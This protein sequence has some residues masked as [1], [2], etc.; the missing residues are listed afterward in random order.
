MCKPSASPARRPVWLIVSSITHTTC[1]R[2]LAHLRRV[3]G[4]PWRV[5]P[6]RT[7]PP[8]AHPAPRVRTP[9]RARRRLERSRFVDRG[10]GCGFA[11]FNGGCGRARSILSAHGHIRANVMTRA[12]GSNPRTGRRLP[13]FLRA[14]PHAGAGASVHGRGRLRGR[15]GH[16]ADRLSLLRA[17]HAPGSRLSQGS[18]E[19]TTLEGTTRHGGHTPAL[20]CPGRLGVAGAALRGNPRAGRATPTSTRRISGVPPPPRPP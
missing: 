15:T 20:R 10:S 8:L 6:V 7:S 5:R 13:V 1:S 12:V 18:P 14:R 4:P 2:G 16:R 3:G 19:P 17:P 9:S 11:G